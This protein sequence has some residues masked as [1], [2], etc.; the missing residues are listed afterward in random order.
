[1]TTASAFIVDNNL[2]N[3]WNH[4]S[5]NQFHPYT[6]KISS[7]GLGCLIIYFIHTQEIDCFSQP[8]TPN[9]KLGLND[10]K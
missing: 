7:Q 6:R 3:V 8:D 2:G 10:S 9:R 4:K 1:M 5:D